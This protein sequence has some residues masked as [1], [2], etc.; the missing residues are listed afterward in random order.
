MSVAILYFKNSN[1]IHDFFDGVTD[2]TPQR[3]EFTGGYSEGWIEDEIGIIVVDTL[4]INFE[5]QED[6]LK[7]GQGNIYK[8]EDI[9]P[10][11]LIDIKEQFIKITD[12]EILGQQMTE[13]E[14]ES[15]E[16]GQQITDLELRM[17]LIE[18]VR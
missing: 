14:I 18:G 10:S 5:G 8:R 16:Q 1:T 2:V 13:R 15:M 3:I 7:D 4:F 9:L 17:L 12:T 6:C 11:G